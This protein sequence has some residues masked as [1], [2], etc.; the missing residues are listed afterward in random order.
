MAFI[1]VIG[2]DEHADRDSAAGFSVRLSAVPSSEWARFFD[3]AWK[4]ALEEEKPYP[5][6]NQDA[7]LI[8]GDRIVLRHVPNELTVQD[9]DKLRRIV[10][11]ANR[12]L[13]GYE[14][15]LRRSH[16]AR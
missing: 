5:P 4:L 6:F 1:D 7:P 10:D 15:L 9:L 11:E 13:G 16:A 12:I 14:E 8:H 3:Q 2:I